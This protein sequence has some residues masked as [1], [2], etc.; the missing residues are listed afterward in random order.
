MVKAGTRNP[1]LVRSE[2]FVGDF[3]AGF[4]AARQRVA[5]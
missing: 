3:F 5:A 1:P 2:R 4:A